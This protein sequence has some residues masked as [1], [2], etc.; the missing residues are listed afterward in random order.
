MCVARNVTLHDV[1][2]TQGVRL[3]KDSVVLMDEN[4]NV[5]DA[6]VQINDD[7]TF[8]LST[9][10][11]LIKDARYSI[12]DNDRGGLFEQVMYNPLDCRQQ[13]TMIVE[14]QAAVI[15]AALAGQKVH[16]TAVADSNEKIPAT[17]EAE[18]WN[19]LCG[20]YA[21]LHL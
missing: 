5:T 14:Y 10:K 11:A 17:G 12:C 21:F 4:G 18:T 16:N 13:K 7:N 6:D 9:G 15:D 19:S 2:D 20:S 3:L 8:L 1:I